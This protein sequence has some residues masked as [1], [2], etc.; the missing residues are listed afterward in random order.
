MSMRSTVT[1][2]DRHSQAFENYTL[3]YPQPADIAN[4]R[5]SVLSHAGVAVLGAQA[6][7]EVQWPAASGW[8][9]VAIEQVAPVENAVQVTERSTIPWGLSTANG[10]RP[11]M[12]NTSLLTEDQNHATCRFPPLG[13]R[14][15][16]LTDC[17]LRRR[18]VRS[19]DQT[20]DE[21]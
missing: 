11:G 1:L 7:D 4:R 16:L 12:H 5:L 13:S 14:I 9:Q 19:A 21:G 17:P 6:G 20:R 10:R 8:R 18:P 2:R 3:V 15:L